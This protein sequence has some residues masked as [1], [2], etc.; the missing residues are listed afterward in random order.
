MC[1]CGIRLPAA[2]AARRSFTWCALDAFVVCFHILFK[3]KAHFTAGH[4]G[5]GILAH[6]SST[7][8]FNRKDFCEL[9]AGP[10]L[11][12]YDPQYLDSRPYGMHLTYSTDAR[13]LVH[14][15]FR[16]LAPCLCELY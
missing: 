6:F 14:S 8:L 4:I 1:L 12:Q 16:N 11:G 13:R 3:P 15:D 9:F 2:A 7:S 5:D 10:P